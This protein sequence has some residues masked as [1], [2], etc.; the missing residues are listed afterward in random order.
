MDIDIAKQIIKSH[1]EFQDIKIIDRHKG[2]CNLIWI[3]EIDKKKYV[4]RQKL[5]KPDYKQAEYEAGFLDA[6]HEHELPIGVPRV[7]RSKSNKPYFEQQGKFFTLLTYVEGEKKY[8]WYSSNYGNEEVANGF[9]IFA[10][11][12]NV[13]ADIHMD[14]PPKRDIIEIME[15]I[16]DLFNKAKKLKGSLVDYLIKNEPFLLKHANECRNALI[17][18]GYKEQKKE[19]VHFDI[20][21]GNMLY[22]G[23]RIVGVFD[24]D[25][26]C[27]QPFVWD[28]C[29]AC[30][31]MCGSFSHV[32]DENVWNN[33]QLKTALTSYNKYAKKELKDIK[34][35]QELFRA[36]AFHCIDFGLKT[37][38]RNHDNDFNLHNLRNSVERLQ[39]TDFSKL[40]L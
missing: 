30:F 18:L 21:F 27:E 32:G 38:I 19:T 35:M 1:I 3:L 16:P 20:H 2:E 5:A 40:L 17:K 33:E 15:N 37:F 12:H 36:T 39:N 31:M 23:D 25:W 24:F 14:N 8:E 22:K 28:F 34:L 7:I 9:E 4:L 26:V 13:F 6:L 29:K 10:K 11:L